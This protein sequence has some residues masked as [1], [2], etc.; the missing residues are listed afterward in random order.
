MVN[1]EWG[2]LQHH[3]STCAN[4]EDDDHDDWCTGCEDGRCFWGSY[5]WQDI[6][7][8]EVCRRDGVR[9][10]EFN[11]RW[12]CIDCYTG[13]HKDVCGCDLWDKLVE[14]RKRDQG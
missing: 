5:Y 10:A 4:I 1:T 2:G 3:Y 7:Q 8:C 6:G 12:S 9:V 11:D 13:L 14:E